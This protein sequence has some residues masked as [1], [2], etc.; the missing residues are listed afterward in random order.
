[1]GKDRELIIQDFNEVINMSLKQ[2]GSWLKTEDS[3]K[4]GQ[5]DGDKESIGHK[6]GKYIVDL[7]RKNQSSYSDDDIAHMQRVIGYVRCHS[8]Q[9]PSGNIKT[10]HWRFSLMNWG[11]DPENAAPA[12]D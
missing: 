4:V 3:Q 1:M 12:I 2:L 7:L 5:K 10:T 6:S 11:H 9:R 8:A